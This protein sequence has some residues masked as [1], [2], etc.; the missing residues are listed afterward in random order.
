MKYIFITLT[1]LF[2]CSAALCQ[3]KVLLSENFNNNKR[4]WQLRNDS[5]F[6]VAISGGNL[7]LQ[8]YRKNFDDRGC[9]WYKKEIKGLN[10]LND[11][12]ITVVAKFIE[13][14]DWGDIFDIQWGSWDSVISS[15]VTSIYQLNF[16][17]RGD[18]KLDYYNKQWNYSLRK[19]ASEI[20]NTNQ[21]RPGEYNR[22]DIVQ[23]DGFVMLYING[24]QFFK[25]FVNPIAGNSIG[26]QGCLKSTWQVDKIII[27]QLNNSSTVANTPAPE[28]ADSIK[29][30][31][32]QQVLQVFPNPFVNEFTVSV[33]A[34]STTT[35]KIELLDMQGKL[36]IQYDR[37][38]EAGK[39]LVRLYADVAPGTYIIRLTADN[40]TTSTK[41]V[42]M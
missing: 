14:G 17:L 28:M 41:I 26:I 13:G 25:Q 22:Y 32:D 37:R 4:G 27:K 36:L 42:K 18:V 38:L 11:F 1:C 30:R 35:S 12:S 9:L 19:M 39:H 8:K 6:S 2:T 5:S 33:T 3:D 10:T 16:F 40:K 34:A 20:N 29:D 24:T 21:Y 7:R 15:K 23:K 31:N